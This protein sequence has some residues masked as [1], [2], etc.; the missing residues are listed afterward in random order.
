M[1]GIRLKKLRLEQ[2]LTQKQL[3]E[4]VN[5]T[6]VS[7]CGYEKG[8][9]VPSLDTL[10]DLAN[11]LKV[12][13]NT[14]VG[15]DSYVVSDNDVDYGLNVSKEELKVLRELRQYKNLYEDLM[16]SPKRTIQSIIKKY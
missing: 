3:G 16:E 14:L 6:K 5:V 12:D 7:I 11:A 9:R 1:L 10:I 2:G 15:F 8:E 4:M 13:L